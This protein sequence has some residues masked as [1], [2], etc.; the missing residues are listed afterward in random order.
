MNALLS[1]LSAAIVAGGVPKVGLLVPADAPKCVK[2]AAEDWRRWVGELTGAE[3]GQ[4]A[5]GVSGGPAVSWRLLESDA[6]LEGIVDEGFVIEADAKGVVIS[7]KNPLSIAYSTFWILR[8][9]GGM[10]WFDPESGCD[11]RP[12]KDLA[13]PDG[14]I[15]RI[16]PPNRQNL[17]PGI[18]ERGDEHI[19]A[20]VANWNIRNGF[21]T[22]EASVSGRY[23][24]I[25]V[26]RE[27]GHA[28][29]DMVNNDFVEKEVLEAEVKRIMD[30]GENVK[31][32]NSPGNRRL[33]EMLARYNIN[34]KRHP[35][36]FPLIGGARRP[37]GVSLRGPYKGPEGNPCISDPECRE[38]LL[39]C[40]RRAK[41]QAKEK[42]EGARIKYTFRLMC[43]DNSQWCECERCLKL[44]KSKGADSRDDRASDLWWDFNN[45]ITP[46]LLEDP[47]MNV[48]NS[49][50]LTYRRM[51]EKV[52]PLVVD[53]HRQHVLYC[54]HGRCYLH[55]LT[56]PVCKAN[57]KYR[58]QFEAWNAIGMPVET[59]EYHCQLPGTGN[60][61]FFERSWVEDLKW[62]RDRRIS[63]TSGGLWGLW[64]GYPKHLKHLHSVTI[65]THGARARWQFL[66]L[67]GHF[68]W[69]PEDD[70][71][72]VQ[73]EMLESYYRRA[74]PEMLEYHRLLE[75]TIYKVGICM[76]YG[77]SG[78][79]FTV[80]AS[81]PG[82]L[83]RA[84]ALLKA[85]EAKAADDPELA[86]RIARDRK[87]LYTDWESAAAVASSVKSKPAFRAIDRIT[88]DGKLNERTWRRASVSDDWRWLKNYN[89]DAAQ[90]DP[91]R[92]ETKMFYSYDN[93]NL[94]LAFGCAKP[95]CGETDVAPDGSTFDAMR[96][97][98]LEINVMSP[99][100]N[101]EYFHLALSHNG[102]TYS[103]RTSSPTERDLAQKCD[104]RFAI[105]EN[106]KRWIAELALPLQAF[107]A[108]PKPGEV[109]RI[110]AYR[111]TKNA[112]GA[113]LDG[114]S[115]GFPFHWQDRW[116]AFSFG[117]P[118]N[119]VGNGSFERGNGNP[120]GVNSKSA[121]NWKFLQTAVPEDWAYHENGG[122]LDWREGDAAEGERY[123]RVTP[124]NDNGGPEFLNTK[125]SL[126]RPDAKALKVAFS[127]RGKGMLR[128]Y[129]FV[130]RE[131]KPVEVN[132]DS[133]DWKRYETELP[134]CG[135]HPTSIVVRFRS[136][137]RDPIDF[138]D[139]TV[140]IGR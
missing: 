88:I 108:L 34:V 112:A 116:E 75:D 2:A 22:E 101:G 46:R 18:P 14:K 64:V 62:F 59:F 74:V 30:S 56:N 24:L 16:P 8:R 89:V 119:L 50:Y 97:G 36:R 100:L 1:M 60:Y 134:L 35:N 133:A 94:Y 124:V 110:C 87:Y 123:I 98:H 83:D 128:L 61:A 86:K 99:K 122:E 70:F 21:D 121:K 32:L 25:R 92:P 66:Y 49:L 103:A 109:W 63:H 129:S 33:V 6:E 114:S 140:N 117:E 38:Y 26:V 51:P 69:D 130:A 57:V 137:K 107:G 23:G 4:C 136:Q 17:R 102:K 53:P 3:L 104:F 41:A 48:G 13:I 113:T 5:D 135:T 138:D 67:T 73:K 91:Y 28:L 77:S 9:F 7:A 29:G 120:H 37:S 82:V 12:L 40:I 84:K 55:S 78:L 76:S 85:A 90:P 93:E 139:F 47:E 15:V 95:E 132:V 44:L 71:A 96:G 126:Y 54:P 72:A 39:G 106:E 10:H 19:Y 105:A 115:T 58:G 125:L 80:G 11:F 68:D 131:L 20:D 52:K 111:S 42:A 79:P 27:G 65:Y 127:C 31:Y 81:E 45:W 43:D 118:G